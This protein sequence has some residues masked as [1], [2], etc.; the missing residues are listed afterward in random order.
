MY[1]ILDGLRS[2]QYNSANSTFALIL[3]TTLAREAKDQFWEPTGIHFIAGLLEEALAGSMS[4]NQLAAL[5]NV[6]PTTLRNLRN[7]LH[8]PDT[9]LSTPDPETLEKLAPYLAN[10][11][12]GKRYLPNELIE[13]ARCG[14]PGSAGSIKEYVDAYLTRKNLSVR[15]L[16]RSLS[17]T[18]LE[19]RRVLAHPDRLTGEERL[20]WTIQLSGRIGN[21]LVIS[22][23]MGI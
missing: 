8:C 10:P 22:Q 11:D 3:M 21:I 7:N 17:V 4:Q 19:L 15:Q 2:I 14:K 9:I 1:S 5:I 13:I 18:E 23:L 16:A 12:T 20:R 6:S